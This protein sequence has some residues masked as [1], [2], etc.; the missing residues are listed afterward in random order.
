MVLERS[1]FTDYVDPDNDKPFMYEG[2]NQRNECFA[3]FA[4]QADGVHKHSVIFQPD[5]AVNRCYGFF[6]QDSGLYSV[7]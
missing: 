7:H 4:D 3:I 1:G 6:A 5:W 2:S